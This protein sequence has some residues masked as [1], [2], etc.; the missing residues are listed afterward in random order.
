MLELFG[1]YS[2]LAWTVILAALLFWPVRQLIWALSVR[3]AEAKAKAVTDAAERA[4]LK[5]RAAFTALLLCLIFA[6]FYTSTLLKD[7]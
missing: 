2:R 3:R 5:R 1:E 4:R 7:G 6:F